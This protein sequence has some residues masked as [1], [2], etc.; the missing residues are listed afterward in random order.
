MLLPPRKARSLL[1]GYSFSP[2]PTCH[3]LKREGRRG[4]MEATLAFTAAKEEI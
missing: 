2:E 3:V 4:K 1:R